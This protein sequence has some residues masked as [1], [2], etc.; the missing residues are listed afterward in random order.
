MFGKALGKVWQHTPE[1]IKS[2]LEKIGSAVAKPF[3]PII[4]PI[5]SKLEKARLWPYEKLAPGIV[6]IPEFAKPT[7]A[8]LMYQE[9]AWDLAVTP[10]SS[11]LLI[12]KYSGPTGER[13]S[14]W[15]ME[16]WLKTVTG[17]LSYSL[18]K[19]ELEAVKPSVRDYA[20]GVPY[21]PIAD[22]AASGSLLLLAPIPR[23]LPSVPR[24]DTQVKAQTKTLPFE[25]PYEVQKLRLFPELIS[26]PSRKQRSV[27]TPRLSLKEV[28]EPKLKFEQAVMPAL[29]MDQMVVPKLKF[30]QAVMP[31]LKMDQMVVP[32]LAQLARLEMV[33]PSLPKQ[34]LRGPS[35]PRRSEFNVPSFG[36]ERG[37][38]GSWFKRTHAMPTGRQIMRELGF[39][40]A[41]RATGK[42]RAKRRKS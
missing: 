17:G 30:E 10:K 27:L 26:K 20:V 28:A 38:F 33:V 24:L 29:K 8:N 42:R 5:M 19:T 25:E 23:L 7:P 12:S 39:G 40:V 14:A 32:K 35:F 36:A 9:W 41:R 2:P 1:L 37:L 16:H 22:V 11:A 34:V 18:V 4:E 31:A 15:V 3:K 6:D 13:A 21:T